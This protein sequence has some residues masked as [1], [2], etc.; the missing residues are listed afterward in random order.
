MLFRFSWE[1]RKSLQPPLSL[2]R[3]FIPVERTVVQSFMLLWTREQCSS[4]KAVPE[5]M[6]F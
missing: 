4:T 2:G 1:C 5:V 3:D 6:L